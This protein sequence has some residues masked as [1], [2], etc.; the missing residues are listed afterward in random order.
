MTKALTTLHLLVPLF[1]AL[2]HAA[3]FEMRQINEL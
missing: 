3:A 1:F 2:A